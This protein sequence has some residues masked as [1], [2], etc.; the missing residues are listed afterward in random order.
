M[1]FSNSRTSILWRQ[2][3]GLAALLAAILLGFMAYGLYQPKILKG[4][5]FVE[6]AGWLGIGQ[7]LLA[8]AIE[9]LV[10]GFSDRILRRVGSRLPMISVGVTL[11]GTLFVVIA[12]L[13]QGNLPDKLRWLVPILMT[14]WLMAMIVFRGPAIALLMQFAPLAELPKASAVLILVLGLVGATGPLL[15]ILFQSLGASPTF[16]LGAIA[17]IIGASILFSSTPKHTLM[18]PNQERQFPASIRHLILIF[19]VGLCAGWEINL[20]M[21]IFPRVLTAQLS[22]V[23]AEFITSGILLVSALTA[24]PLEK[25]TGKLGITTALSLGLGA[26]PAFMGASLPNLTPVLV[27]ALI[28]AF[29]VALGLIFIAQIPY[30]LLMV[31]PTNAGLG[32]GLYFGGMGAATALVTALMQQFTGVTPIQGVLWSAIAFLVALP[33]LGFSRLKVGH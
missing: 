20:L 18:L 5:G 6:L 25:L 22:G 1:Q 32:T 16:I 24:V 23:R 26:I 3:W 19:T 4:L 28:L 15:S 7:G 29:G 17:L 12:L 33:C 9:P 11:A 30:A 31:P 13:I 2:I 10:G 27:F 8:A 21:A 14:V